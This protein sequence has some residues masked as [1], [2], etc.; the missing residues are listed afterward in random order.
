[1]NTH[2]IAADAITAWDTGNRRR[3]AR[4]GLD[5][6]IDGT[7]ASGGLLVVN[8]IASLNL[9]LPDGRAGMSLGGALLASG[10]AWMSHT[11]RSTAARRLTAVQAPTYATVRS[12]HHAA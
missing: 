5:R 3:R 7:M 6:C 12:I 10:L 4:A 1:M 9:G 11:R 8:A 2:R